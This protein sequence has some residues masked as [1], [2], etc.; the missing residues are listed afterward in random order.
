M[1]KKK[2]KI[3]NEKKKIEK[4]KG[5]ESIDYNFLNQKLEDLEKELFIYNNYDIH[6]AN[7][8]IKYLF[9]Y[10]YKFKLQNIDVMKK[11]KK[12]NYIYLLVSFMSNRLSVYQVNLYD[13]LHNKDNFVVMDNENKEER[14][15]KDNMD[16]ESDMKD[17]KSGNNIDSDIE[18]GSDNDSDNKSDSNID[19]DN[20]SG[21]NIDSNIDSDNKSGSN[22][23]SGED[24]ETH[25][26][27]KVKIV[28]KKIYDYSKCFK[29]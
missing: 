6:T 10:N 21:N 12:D 2:I 4:F 5:K 26:K 28:Q 11:K 13:I 22:I 25:N 14:E 24:D 7:D 16:R 17:H 20:E 19:S 27:K 23:D 18:S 3:L 15:D 1:K 29:K 9:N 8:E